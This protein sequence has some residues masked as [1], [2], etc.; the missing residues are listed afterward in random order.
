MYNNIG[1]CQSI[2]RVVKIFSFILS[3]VTIS[4]GIENDPIAFEITA[5]SDVLEVASRGCQGQYQSCMRLAAP[6]IELYSHHNFGTPLDNWRYDKY[7]KCSMPKQEKL[8]IIQYL[9]IPK[10]STSINWA[11]HAYF[12]DCKVNMSN[13]CS[14]F[15][16]KPEELQR[17][18]C[19]GHLFSCAGHVV[20]PHLPRETLSGKTNLVTMLR[21]PWNRLQSDFYYLKSKPT[22]EHLG[23]NINVSHVLSTASSVFEY[24]I[25]PGISNCITKMLNGIQCTQKFELTNNHLDTAKQVVAAMLWFG[26]TEMFK[27]SVCQFNFMYGGVT[28]E[29]QFK[30]SREG[31]YLYEEMTV[32]LNEDELNLFLFNE[33]FDI[34]VYVFALRIFKSRQQLT[35]CPYL[36]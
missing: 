23:P 14:A 18:L 31:S 6:G 22:S 34:E 10:T 5:T 13:P 17:G 4:S 12:E 2:I 19:R 16:T 21:H 35:N 30:K 36:E 11:L 3:I 27:T 28:E 8:D 33:R 1:L 20:S 26:I 29:F 15:L 25:Y 32:A 24:S 7:C 9:H